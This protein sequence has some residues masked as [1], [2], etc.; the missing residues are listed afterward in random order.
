MTYFA[1][2]VAV[3]TGAASGIGRALAIDLA[4][5]GARLAICDIDAEGLHETEA[6]A[7]RYGAQVRAAPLDVTD[8]AAMFAYADEVAE[9]FAAVHLLINNAGITFVGDIEELDFAALE[10]VMD[11]DYWGVVNGTK[12]FLPHLIASRDGHVVTVSSVFGILASPTQGAYN[13]AKFAV[14]G[15]TETL[16][17]EMLLRER[18]VAVTAVHPGGIKTGIARHTGTTEGRDREN[19]EAVFERIARTTP[20]RA[21]E[22]ILRGVQ[23]RKPRVLI[24]PD[25]VALDILARIVG[26]GYQRL[27]A[28]AASRTRL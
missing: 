11:V 2:R 22:V 21:A 17:I 26:P 24:G 3:V 13:A 14:R 25:A 19:I 16:R 7:A 27:L 9:H 12:A 10:R 6:L 15:F 5:R 23:R 8:R 18:P 4:K 1:G 20:E 28:C